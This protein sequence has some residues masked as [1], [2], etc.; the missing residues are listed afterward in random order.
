[1]S[2]RSLCR[3]LGLQIRQ[4]RNSQQPRQSWLA[5]SAVQANAAGNLCSPGN[6]GRQSLQSRQSRPAILNIFSTSKCNPP[7]AAVNLGNIGNPGNLGR[8]SGQSRQ[9]WQN[10]HSQHYQPS[11]QSLSANFLNL[12][13]NLHLWA[14][15][16]GKVAPQPPSH[17]RSANS[18]LS[19]NPT[20]S[21]FLA[22]KIGNS[23]NGSL[24]NSDW[25]SRPSMPVAISAF[26]AGNLGR[27]HWQYRQAQ[28]SLATL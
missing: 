14:G 11:R 22:G 12:A 15:I 10:L 18:A 16:F 2:S 7:F 6:R 1:M 3:N 5:I 9:S 23:S 19:R 4:P 26:L 17:S 13:C 8:H 21:G 28:Q 24:G 25:Q 27:Q 20:T